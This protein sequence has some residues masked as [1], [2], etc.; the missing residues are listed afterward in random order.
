MPPL[1]ISAAGWLFGRA[2]GTKAGVQPGLRRYGGSLPYPPRF[3]QA[4]R[5]WVK[6]YWSP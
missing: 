4:V 5:C 6:C 3:R 1:D 2:G